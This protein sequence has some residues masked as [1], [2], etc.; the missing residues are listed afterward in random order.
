MA[1]AQATRERCVN[2]QARVR[3]VGAHIGRERPHATHAHQELGE[4]HEHDAHVLDHGEQQ[5]LD[6]IHLLAVLAR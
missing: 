2:V 6:A 5:I 3:H 1:H 4:L